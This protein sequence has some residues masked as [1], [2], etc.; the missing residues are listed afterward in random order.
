MDIPRATHSGKWTIDSEH[1][2]SV[3]CYVMDNEERVLSLRGSS[4]AMGLAGGGGGALARNLNAQWINPYLSNGLKDWL[5]KE[6][7]HELPDY[8]A[9]NG[10]RFTPI[11]ASLFID[12]CKAY[13]DAHHEGILSGTQVVVAKRMYAIMTAFAKLGLVAIID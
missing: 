6:S 9:T 7:R 3:E 2:I 13:V 1:N 4:R 8:I 10:R 11:E 12:I 5:G